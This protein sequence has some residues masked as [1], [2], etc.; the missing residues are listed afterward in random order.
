[1]HEDAQAG[2][3]QAK[4]VINSAARVNGRRNSAFTTRSRADTNV[5]AW[6]MPIQKRY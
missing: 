5:P 4:V 1:M 3:N 2:L 6:L